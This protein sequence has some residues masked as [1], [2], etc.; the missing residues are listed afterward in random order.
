MDLPFATGIDLIAALQGA[1]WLDALMR[2]FSFL[3]SEQ[4][5]MFVLPLVYWGIDAAL[6]V[7]IGLILLFGQFFNS[8]VKLGLRSPRPYWTD[9]QLKALAAESSFGAPSGHA[10]NAVGIWGTVGAHSR[11]NA[12]WWLAGALIFLIGISRLYLA[13]HFPLDVLLGWL[14][15]ALTLWAFLALW[16]RL[17][18]WVG[19]R[20]LLQQVLLAAGL[21]A[22]LL[23]GNG[24]LTYGLRGYVLPADWIAN[25]ARAGAQPAPLAMEAAL[26]AAGAM[27][28]L[29]LGLVWVGR[30]GG[31][32]PPAALW[33]RLACV[34]VG[35]LGVA[36]IYLGLKAL[37]PAGE[38]LAA[39]A[40]R[41]VRY[42]LLGV[43]I[44][45]GAPWVFARLGLVT[46]P[47]GGLQASGAAA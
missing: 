3:G 16:D 23:A 34:L 39:S 10:Q 14:L 9:P 1:G 11:R 15:G 26:S 20:T 8:L 32:R 47:A 30:R 44:A 12:V 35:I 13:V 24:L 6:G 4:F 40:W 36:V 21:P 46:Q 2:F 5:Y 37:L 45:G 17:A 43:W 22:L 38:S 18:A 41:L 33:R 7:R 25:A 27:L 42:A 28:G 29:D 31:Y 19:R